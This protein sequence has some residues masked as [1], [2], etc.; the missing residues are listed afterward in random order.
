MKK[1]LAIVCVLLLTLVTSCMHSRTKNNDKLNIVCT[2]FPQYDFARNI[3]KDRVSLSLLLP[4]GAEAHSYEPSPKDILTLKEADIFIMTGGESEH[5]AEHLLSKKDKEKITVIRLMES[6]TAHEEEH[7]EGMEESGHIHIHETENEHKEY[8]EHIWTSPKN[9]IKMCHAIYEVLCLADEENKE[10]YKENLLKYKKELAGLAEE[11][12]SISK[13]AKRKTLVFGDR[14]PM[15]YLTEDMGI[16]YFA[17]FP[18]CSSKTEPSAKTVA[19]LS[20]KVMSEKIPVVFYM[21]YS[22]GRIARVIA[23]EAGAKERRLY[24]CHNLSKKDLENGENY[25]SLMTKNLKEIKEALN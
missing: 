16:D 20:D 7:T 10:F 18:G 17:A 14:F 24:S 6:V 12:E 15:R 3:A 13:N 19:F 25:I 21:D 2:V 5:W 23:N 4:P 22:D 9:A 8:D 11:F 1:L